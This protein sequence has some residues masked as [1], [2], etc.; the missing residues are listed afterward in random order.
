M[1]ESYREQTFPGELQRF[2]SHVWPK[3]QP[4]LVWCSGLSRPRGREDWSWAQGKRGISFL[5]PCQ[6][7]CWWRRW[8]R[9]QG[10]GAFPIVG[11]VQGNLPVSCSVRG[12]D[13]SRIHRATPVWVCY[14]DSG[15]GISIRSW[16]R[17]CGPNSSPRL[18]V[19]PQ[20][21]LL[22][23]YQQPL[24]TLPFQRS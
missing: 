4:T 6:P 22:G 19:H 9:C 5:P 2:M 14:V 24:S 21:G 18:P 23:A 16:A 7:Y 10:W 13:L 1:S 8:K 11:S 3:L 20:T 15:A 12:R 17:R